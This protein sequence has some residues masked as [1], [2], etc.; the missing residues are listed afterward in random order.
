MGDKVGFKELGI[1]TGAIVSL[2]VIFGAVYKADC[3]NIRVHGDEHFVKPLEV[4]LEAEKDFVTIDTYLAG[5]KKVFRK[6]DAWELEKKQG[7]INDYD[8]QYGEGCQRCDPK[9]KIYYDW[10]KLER[11]KLIKRAMDS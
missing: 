1:I 10:L 8:K 7:L 9:L 3:F 2:L 4:K 6:F 5:Q 11:D